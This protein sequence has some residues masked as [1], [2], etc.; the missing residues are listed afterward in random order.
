MIPPAD[1]E[2]RLREIERELRLGHGEQPQRML[3]ELMR[4]MRRETLGEWKPTL[5][6]IIDRFGLRGLLLRS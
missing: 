1:T 4:D 6:P 3:M 5:E 2:A